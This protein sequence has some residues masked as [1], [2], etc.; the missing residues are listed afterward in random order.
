MELVDYYKAVKD[1]FAVLGR[2]EDGKDSN[3]DD[4]LVKDFYFTSMAQPKNS[5]VFCNIQV[6]LNKNSSRSRAWI[7]IRSWTELDKS[8]PELKKEIDK[9]AN[10]E[11]DD[12]NMKFL[13]PKSVV[14]VN[15][16]GLSE[17]YST[18][19]ISFNKD[20]KELTKCFFDQMLKLQKLSDASRA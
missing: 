20:L 15:I 8:T 9:I 12:T 11:N 14:L 2:V 6:M 10:D 13:P 19:D 4:L 17:P 1:T 3:T 7:A 5:K 16:R 18:N